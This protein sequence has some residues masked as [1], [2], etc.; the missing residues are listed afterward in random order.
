MAVAVDLGG[1]AEVELE[2]VVDCD[3]RCP[4]PVDRTPTRD[5]DQAHRVVAPVG[6]SHILAIVAG[7]HH[8]GQRA[9]LH[10]PHDGVG[11]GV[12]HRYGAG[13]LRVQVVAAAVVGYPQVAALVREGTL[14]RPPPEGVEVLAVVGEMVKP[15]RL[16]PQVGIGIGKPVLDHVQ[17]FASRRIIDYRHAA[18]KRVD[19]VF[20]AVGVEMCRLGRVHIGV[21]QRLVAAHVVELLSS[22]GELHLAM[23]RGS[24]VA[25]LAVK[26]R[27]HR[28]VE[29]GND[30]TGPGDGYRPEYQSRNV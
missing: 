9:G 11:P 12:D 15:A 14:H 16:G 2:L 26:H 29:L 4:V 6:H 25:Y 3:A 7:G 30:T 22:N 21:A 17:L 1:S 24:L 13:V 19:I 23:P 28:L 27:W 10:Y 20:C 18:L 5:I 8:L